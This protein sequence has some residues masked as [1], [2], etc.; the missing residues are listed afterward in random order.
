MIISWN[1][2]EGEVS[3][4]WAWFN[5]TKI[6]IFLYL[7]NTSV[8]GLATNFKSSRIK[9]FDVSPI[10]SSTFSLSISL[11]VF[12][13]VIYLNDVYLWAHQSIFLIDCL[14]FFLNFFFNSLVLCRLLCIAKVIFFIFV[15]FFWF[16]SKYV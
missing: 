12:Q 13:K 16:L 6:S 10:M 3:F 7:S 2:K 11:T 9:V 14:P 1:W 15:S 5:F 4:F 8:F